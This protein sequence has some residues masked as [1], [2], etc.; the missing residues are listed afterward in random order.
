MLH[1]DAAVPLPEVTHIP[2]A[3]GDFTPS[4]QKNPS[5]HSSLLQLDEDSPLPAKTQEP[6]PH[7]VFTPP[8]Q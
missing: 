2:G 6:A 1:E 7:A 4:R 8:T 3:H 5:A